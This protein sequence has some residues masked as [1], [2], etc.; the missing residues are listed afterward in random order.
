MMNALGVAAPAAGCSCC[1][2][3]PTARGFSCGCEGEMFCRG[4]NCCLPHCR[5]KGVPDVDLPPKTWAE[6][7]RRVWRSMGVVL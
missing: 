1:A 4:C 6:E 3:V 5:C 2:T 7:I